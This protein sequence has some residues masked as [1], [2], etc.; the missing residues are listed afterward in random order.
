VISQNY[1]KLIFIIHSKKN[2]F[3]ISKVISITKNNKFKKVIY[4]KNSIYCIKIK[5]KMLTIIKIKIINNNI[6][7]NSTLITVVII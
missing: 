6:T 7:I 1:V 5:L 2:K 4:C 3:L